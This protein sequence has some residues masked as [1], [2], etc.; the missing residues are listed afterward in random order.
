MRLLPIWSD[1][2]CCRLGFLMRRFGW[3]GFQARHLRVCLYTQPAHLVSGTAD[4]S[5]CDAR[6]PAWTLERLQH[7][8]GLEA[9]KSDHRRTFGASCTTTAKVPML[10]HYGQIAGVSHRKGLPKNTDFGE[11]MHAKVV[12]DAWPLFLP[13][14]FVR[15]QYLQGPVAAN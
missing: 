5:L 3:C 8:L 6:W 1:Q 10:P 12:C 13:K 9:T 7:P 11:I 4:Q 15:L 14:S 2:S